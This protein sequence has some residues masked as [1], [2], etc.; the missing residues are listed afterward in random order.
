MI[1]DH[2]LELAAA[3]IDFELTPAERARLEKAI[4]ECSVCASAAASYRRQAIL[5]QALPVVDASPMVRR[6][7]ERA[8]GVRP[9]RTS[10]TW[11]VLAA[12][13]LGLLLTSVLVAGAIDRNRKSGL[14][15]VSPRPTPY[16]ASQPSALPS[17]LVPDVVALDPPSG[18]LADVGPPLAHDSIA[19]VVTKNLRVRSAPFVGDASA[20]YQPFLQPDDR[21]FVVDGPVFAQNY[22]WYQVKPWR[23]RD[24]ARSWPVGWVARAGHDG[25]VWFRPSSPSCSNS[26]IDVATLLTLAPME[27]LA[28]Y[29]DSPIEVRAVVVGPASGDCD[30]AP[31]GCPTGP[32]L[33]TSGSMIAALSAHPPSTADGVSFA[34]DPSANV[35]AADLASVGVVRLRGAFDHPDAGSCRPD[36]A[37]AGADGPLSPADAVLSCRSRFVVT[38]ADV[39]PYPRRSSA[40]AVTVSDRLRV[41]S[42]PQISDASIR[43]EPLV[44]IGTRL[45]VLD[46][47]TLGDGY[48]W[49]QVVVPIASGGGSTVGRWLTGWVAAASRDGDPWIENESIDCPPAGTS[50]ALADLA[51]IRQRPVDD[52]PLAC[53]GASEIRI[54]GQAR[55]H[56]AR[57]N[58]GGG[59]DTDWLSERN[60]TWLEIIDGN[61]RLEARIEPGQSVDVPCDQVLRG[62]YVISG[63]FDDPAAARCTSVAEA[64]PGSA[65]PQV[66]M[67][68]CRTYFVATGVEPAARAAVPERTAPGG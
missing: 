38:H 44:P 2:E 39:E 33:L 59:G 63:H 66:A 5:L 55:L 12:A 13:M 46:G 31:R 52:G 41:R 53:F 60:G 40:P 30:A 51:R 42:L 23:P 20:R 61:R 34:V 25:E 62:R 8:I 47:P 3:A 11:A 15:D 7:V 58:P 65:D 49:Y 21:L 18:D 10:W 54:D 45:F 37:H 32:A 35:T 48:V 17:E 19:A 14:V 6:N 67:Y 29:H 50:L 27:R 43:Y 9:Q 28:C 57:A 64:A 4:A 26:P 24:P 1:H 22:E 56:C 16:E 68:R 36:P